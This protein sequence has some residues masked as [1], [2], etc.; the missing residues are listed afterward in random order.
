MPAES[1]FDAKPNRNGLRG[2]NVRIDPSGLARVTSDHIQGALAELDAAIGAGGGVSTVTGTKVVVAGIS[3]GTFFNT[4]VSSNDGLPSRRVDYG[5]TAHIRPIIENP[6]ADRDSGD[7]TVKV[8]WSTANTP[9]P[10]ETITFQVGYRFLSEGS[11]LGDWTHI[12]IQDVVEGQSWKHLWATDFIIPAASINPNADI[13]GLE[14]RR[15]SPDGATDFGV[16]A[17]SGTDGQVH[18]HQ[19]HIIYLARGLDI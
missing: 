3:S 7:V 6:F 9:G 5:Q 14:V 10:G 16:A 2:Q 17:S 4:T 18:I 19:I 15:I 8:F 12:T 1:N 11:P 13:F